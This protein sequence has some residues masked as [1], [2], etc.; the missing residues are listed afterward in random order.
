MCVYIH[1]QTNHQG[2][3]VVSLKGKMGFGFLPQLRSISQGLTPLRGK[4]ACSSFNKSDQMIFSVLARHILLFSTTI[5]QTVNNHE[6]NLI[7]SKGFW[8]ALEIVHFACSLHW[9]D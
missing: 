2:S 4:I 8:F 3:R 6:F 5:F 7:D 9:A 1:N